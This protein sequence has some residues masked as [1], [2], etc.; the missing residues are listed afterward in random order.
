MPLSA[1]S[2][3][4]WISGPIQTVRFNGYPTMRISGDA[5]PGR[6]TGEAMAEM[7]RLGAVARRFAFE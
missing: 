2:T 4:R 1:P 5:A 3:T 7:E 6:S